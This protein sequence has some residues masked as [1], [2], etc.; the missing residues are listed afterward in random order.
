MH[1]GTCPTAGIYSGGDSGPL[2]KHVKFS[3]RQ[4][5][6]L[7]G[8][9]GMWAS[10]LGAVRHL[11]SYVILLCCGQY[12][13]DMHVKYVKR[14]LFRISVLL[15]ETGWSVLGAEGRLLGFSCRLFGRCTGRGLITTYSLKLPE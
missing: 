1:H 5:S 7:N 10:D 4:K 2:Y 6:R 14:H 15:I 12:R 3:Y 13:K 8:H 11:M 9:M